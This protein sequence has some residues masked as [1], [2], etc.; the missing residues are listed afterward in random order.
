M[1]QKIRIGNYIYTKIFI[2][3]SKYIK[4]GEVKLDFNR[5]DYKRN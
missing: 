3:S 4:C 5:K 2:Y 1:E